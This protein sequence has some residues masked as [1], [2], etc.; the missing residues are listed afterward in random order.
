MLER[1][2]FFSNAC[3]QIFE[4]FYPVGCASPSHVIHVTCTGYISPSGAQQVVAKRNWTSQVTHAYHMGCYASLPA[5]RMAQAFSISQNQNVDVVH[6]ELCSLHLN[7]SNH[8]PEQI[9]VQSLF[10]DGFIKYEVGAQP[11]SFEILKIKELIIPDSA[12]MMTWLTSDFGMQMSLSKDVPTTIAKHLTSFLEEFQIDFE[13]TIFAI[14]PGGPRIIDSIQDLLKL[15]EEK[16]AHAKN[17]LFRYGN[18]S[19]A[20]LPHIWQDIA[21]DANVA[22]GTKIMS[23]AFG[24]GL[25]IFGGLLQKI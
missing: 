11:T 23:L 19:S 17:V 20:T 22:S 8:S 6:T 16:V 7:P 4:E 21:S 25:T 18:M 10:A 14:H 2:Q 15:P 24:P 12:S 5:V 13:N 9:V 1:T 3:N